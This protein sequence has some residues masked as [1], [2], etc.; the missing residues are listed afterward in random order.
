MLWDKGYFPW[1]A[2]AIDGASWIKENTS[3]DDIVSSFNSGIFTVLSGKNLINLDGVVNWGAI[4]AVRNRNVTSYM[5]S[6]N[7]SYWI[8]A[9]FLDEDIYFKHMRGEEIDII[10]ELKWSDILD[11]KERLEL[12]Y[13]NYNI[14]SGISGR[15][16]TV[17]WFVYKLT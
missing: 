17:V 10:N 2:T 8:D 11:E 16:S 12:I 4:N 9:A 15:N 3:D 6:K 14:F 7:V 13:S 5:I 1:Q